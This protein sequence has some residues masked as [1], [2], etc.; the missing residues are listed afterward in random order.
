MTE[1]LRREVYAAGFISDSDYCSLQCNGDDDCISRTNCESS[2]RT[3]ELDIDVAGFCSDCSGFTG[4]TIEQTPD[5]SLSSSF[6]PTQIIAASFRLSDGRTRSV[7]F[8]MMDGEDGWQVQNIEG[9][10]GSN[11]RKIAFDQSGGGTVWYREAAPS[12]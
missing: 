8:H 3:A 9:P 11:L 4:L 2:G 7:Y 10:D 6:L 5:S 1:E 12:N